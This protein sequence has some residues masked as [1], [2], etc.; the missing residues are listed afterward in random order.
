MFLLL[1]PVR[2]SAAK[3]RTSGV[4][5]PISKRSLPRLATVATAAVNFHQQRIVLPSGTNHMEQKTR[6]ND[7]QKPMQKRVQKHVQKLVL[8]QTVIRASGDA[9]VSYESLMEQK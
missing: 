6:A 3:R 2:T 9:L 5:F 8:R 1:S 7:V 4:R